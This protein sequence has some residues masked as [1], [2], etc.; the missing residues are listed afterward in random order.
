MPTARHRKNHKKKVQA[1][2][3]RQKD[4]KRKAEKVQ[5]EFIMNLIEQER[6]KGLF[7][8]NPTINPVIPQIDGPQIDLTSGPII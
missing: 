6:Q 4:L 8:N 7:E 3:Q 1:H 5:R 2:K